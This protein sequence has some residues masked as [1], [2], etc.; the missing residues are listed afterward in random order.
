MKISPQ[1]T[2]IIHFVG[3]GGIGM[4]G[5]AEILHNLGYTVRGSDLTEN[6]NVE[7]LKKLGIKIFNGHQ[8]TNVNN[9]SV[10]VISSDI[11]KDNIELCEARKQ[12][13][14]VILRA[15]MLAELMNLKFSVAVAGTHGKTTTTSMNAA[16]MDA[17]GLDPVVINGGIINA[18]GTNARLGA[19]QWIVAEA[20]ESDGT[21]LKLPRTIAVVTNID[22]EHMDHYGTFEA[23]K[24]AFHQFILGVPFYGLAVLCIDHPVVREL[25]ESIQDRRLVT[26]GFHEKADIRAENLRPTPQGTQF[27]VVFSKRF[28]EVCR[29]APNIANIK[30]IFLS[31]VGEHNVQNVLSAIATG[32]ELG[33]SFEAIRQALEQF[34]GV[35][36]RFTKVGEV[37]GITIIDDYAHHP[38]EIEAVLKTAK[39]VCPGR[40]VAVFQPHRYSRLSHLFDDFLRCFSKADCVVVAP[41]Y[42]AGEKPLSNIT[43]QKFAEALQKNFKGEI[44]QISDPEE[45]APLIHRIV[46]EKDYVVCL[47]AGSITAWAK[48]LPDQLTEL[49]RP[50]LKKKAIG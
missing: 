20:D 9:A 35:K 4:S 31:M 13:I 1:T 15:E 41:V 3:I 26:Y 47:G 44:Y 19:G 7:R 43:H 11:K 21:F 48:N 14:P 29:K 22:P 34:Q 45:L 30:D 37:Q 16:V 38:K 33:L 40:V 32:C 24:N 23:L 28:F 5:I 10:V 49:S 42:S 27:D 50:L 12:S 46:E 2:G 39:T 17:G 25:A 6:A 18:Y 8:E 36:R